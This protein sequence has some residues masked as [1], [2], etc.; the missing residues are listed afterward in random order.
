MSSDFRPDFGDDHDATSSSS[1]TTLAIG[2][3]DMI[4]LIQGHLTSVGLTTAVTALRQES[5]IGAAGASHPPRMFATWAA[6]GNWA[7]VL[8]SLSAIDRQR[9][10]GCTTDLVAAV[11]EQ[12]ILE[13]AEAGDLEVAYATYRLAQ[14]DLEAS[15]MG[16][17]TKKKKKKQSSSS[18]NMTRARNVE[19]KLAAL[20]AAR[21]K[22]PNAPL[23]DD[24]YHNVSG[25][26]N[27]KE[28]TTRDDVRRELG[29]RLTQAIPEQPGNRLT[30]MLQ[31]AIKYQSY[32]GELPRIKQWWQ[33]EEN[34]QSD[35]DNAD[36]RPKKKRRKVFDL[37]LGTSTRAP[38]D[39]VVVG[40]A[41]RNNE[42]YSSRATFPTNPIGTV[43]FGKRAVCEAAVFFPDGSALAT[44]S[45]DGLV[46]IWDAEKAYTELRMDL[47]YQQ[48]D[49]LLGHNVAVT[50][51]DVSK[52]CTLL[53]SGDAEGQVCV[54]R[55]D[56]GKC[57]R[58][59]SCHSQAISCLQ[60][61]PDGSHILTSSQ[62]GKCREFGLRTA[63]MLKEFSGSSTTGAQ[64]DSYINS[65][66][67]YVQSAQGPRVVTALADG[68][69]QIFDHGSGDCIKLLRP[70]VSEKE[71]SS[72]AVDNQGAASSAVSNST[73]AA[74]V[75]VMKLNTPSKTMI[76]VPRGPRAYL[77]N[78]QGFI[79]RVF[80]DKTAT[81]MFCA[82]SVSSSN[83]WLYAVKEEGTLCIFDIS[84]G[85]L[86]GSI[87]DFG[88][89][90]TK[91]FKDG[92]HNSSLSSPEISSLIPHPSQHQLAAFSNSK[93][94]KK[95]QLVVWK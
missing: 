15:R 23:P 46:E 2:G 76:V 24:Y 3:A 71:G 43:K 78:M 56:T 80:E 22:D 82:A 62:D 53:A 94:Q 55:I 69:V 63:K 42:S 13:V 49:E 93:G 26:T 5:G 88:A 52:D 36:N 70:S 89:E 92:T 29:D 44:G 57:L 17:Q 12:A 59:L 11:H 51:L 54:W 86:E 38:T 58:T 37:V 48:K 77:V 39:S 41:S 72:I 84:S 50:A 75:G 4:R 65:C 60:F 14:K 83:L 68:S 32:T 95:G 90:S 6:E 61:S 25:G 74:I 10:R 28:M 73:S 34:E 66:F 8:K 64:D 35:N 27:N 85:K 16:H 91:K 1:S 19:Q 20:A 87:P 21:T 30:A 9:C 33:D 79:L 40:D 18:S 47:P 7:L 81:G 31:Q 67:Y 45:S